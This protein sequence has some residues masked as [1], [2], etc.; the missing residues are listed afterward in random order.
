MDQRIIALLAATIQ[1]A[2]LDALDLNPCQA[3]DRYA[4]RL[5]LEYAGLDDARITQVAELAQLKDR[6][7]HG[8]RATTRRKPQRIAA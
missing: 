2:A 6:S 8:L 7:E 1:Q 4:A 3:T 5:F